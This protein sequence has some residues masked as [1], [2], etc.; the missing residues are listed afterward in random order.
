M[1]PLL[2]RIAGGET[3]VGDCAM[4]TQLFDLGL[5]PGDCPERWN[6]DHPD[7]IERIAAASV[8]AG[9]DIVQTNTFGGSPLKLDPYGLA[10]AAREINRAAVEAARRG[11]GGRAYV[12][13]TCGPSGR[14]LA[15]CGTADPAEIR[16]SFRIQIEALL[17]AGVDLVCVET[18]TDLAEA[19]LA[20]EAAREVSR[21][22]P[23]AATLT[24]DATPRG[25]F[26][27]MGIDV[28]AA[29]RGLPEAGADLVGANC[30]AGIATMVE[31]ARAFRETTARPLIVQS[32]AG[33]PRAA[34]E[35]IV[36]PEGP[37]LFFEAGRELVRIGVSVIGGC[38]GTTPEH[39]AALRRAVDEAGGAG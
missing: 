17:Q 22:I 7:R 24:F 8:A 37:D 21:E 2:D 29:A 23:L 11:A 30:G 6:L 33:L 39:V 36:Y 27:I 34:G 32:N 38:C 13:G 12:A 1:R 26:T 4:G 20:C 3:L 31:I 19:L 16:E 28:A 35:G 25:F 18:M 15:P 9:A 10:G 14:L 5:A